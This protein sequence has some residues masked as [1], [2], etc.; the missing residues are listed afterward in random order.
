M[1]SSPLNKTT[2]LITKFFISGFKQINIFFMA[3]IIYALINKLKE[4][5][6]TVWGQ[7]QKIMKAMAVFITLLGTNY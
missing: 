1:Q 7:Y 6:L 5:N 2:K 4:S 3:I